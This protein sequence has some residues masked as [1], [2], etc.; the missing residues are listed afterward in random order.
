MKTEKEIREEIAG[1]RRLK[2]SITSSLQKTIHSCDEQI[3]ALQ[4][5]LGDYR[6]EEETNACKSD[7]K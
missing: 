5:V 3:Y 2:V 4:W 1:L 6:T 7:S